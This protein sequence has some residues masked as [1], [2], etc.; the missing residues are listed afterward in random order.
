MAAGEAEKDSAPRGGF[1]G[2]EGK[3]LLDVCKVRLKRSSA[4]DASQFSL[5]YCTLMIANA[6]QSVLV[7]VLIVGRR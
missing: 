5:L 2:R 6:R 3:G 7:L 4:R 1:L